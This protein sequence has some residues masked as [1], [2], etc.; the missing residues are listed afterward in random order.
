MKE[1]KEKGSLRSW[2]ETRLKVENVVVS[3]T[4]NTCAN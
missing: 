3:R 1:E 4:K 2:D